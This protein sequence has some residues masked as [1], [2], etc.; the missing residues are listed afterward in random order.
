MA[1]SKSFKAEMAQQPTNPAATYISA[2]PAAADE[3]EYKT[4]RLNLMIKPTV[5]AKIEKI[6]AMQRRSV[7]E[8]INTVLEAYAE[9]KAELVRKYDAT[10]GEEG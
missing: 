4:K 7:N 10:F 2:P 3:R 6:A 9:D 1:K 8:L 5:H